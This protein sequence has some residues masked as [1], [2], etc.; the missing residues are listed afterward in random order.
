MVS[1]ITA[2]D[3]VIFGAGPGDIDRWIILG[4]DQKGDQEEGE[5]DEN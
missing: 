5:D 2:A 3:H 1:K 4:P